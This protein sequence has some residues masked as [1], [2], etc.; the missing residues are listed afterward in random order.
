MIKFIGEANERV[1]INFTDF[2]LDGFP[3]ELAG[4]SYG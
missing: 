1:Q 3:N 2:K 4:V